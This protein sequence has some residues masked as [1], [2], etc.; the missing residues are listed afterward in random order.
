MDGEFAPQWRPEPEPGNALERLLQKAA[1]D[2]AMHGRMLR[3]LWGAELHTLIEYHPELEG[4]MQLSNGS[5]MPRFMLVKDDTG[6]FI[7]VFSSEAVAEYC[8]AKHDK[9]RGPKA[10]AC[11]PGEAFFIMMAQLKHDVILNPGMTHRLL[12]K[13]EAIADLV[14]GEMRHSRPS[15]GNEES[16]T[17]HGV[18]E[19]SIPADFRDGI[20]RFC[21]RNPVPIAVYLFVPCRSR[22]RSGRSA[23]VAS[24]PASPQRGKGADSSTTS[25][26]LPA[27]F[28]HPEPSSP[29]ASSPTMKTPSPSPAGVGRCGRCSASQ[30]PISVHDTR[31]P[32]HLS[33]A[34]KLT[35]ILSPLSF[36]WWQPGSSGGS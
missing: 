15:H 9:S 5:P 18:E 23:P 22:Y 11:M 24:Y 21:D 31:L 26:S 27:N 8:I 10:V 13:P 30:L 16:T 32:D 33:V 19:D 3:A 34:H 12:L 25:A 7:P 36:G 1:T 17:L 35:G 6:T 2:P 29:A 14:S 20:R 4:E 28:S